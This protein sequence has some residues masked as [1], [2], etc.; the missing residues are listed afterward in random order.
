MFHLSMIL[1]EE[2][3]LHVALAISLAGAVMLGFYHEGL[4]IH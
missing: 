2:T 4:R 1:S 3:K